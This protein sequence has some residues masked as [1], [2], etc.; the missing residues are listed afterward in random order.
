MAELLRTEQIQIKGNDTLSKMCHISKNLYN[1][2]NYVIRQEFFNNGKWIRYNELDKLMQ[3]SENYRTLPSA[4]SQQT[5]RVLDRNWSSFFKANK[6]YKN[7]PSKFLGKPKPPKYLNKDGEFILIFSNTK[8]KIKDG[9]LIIALKNKQGKQYNRNELK[10]KTRFSSNTNLREVRIIPKSNHYVCEIIYEKQSE[11]EIISR[12][13]YSKLDKN[14][15]KNIIGIDYG[16]SNIVTI[17]NNIGLPPI[18]IKDDG[19]GIKSIN[20]YYNKKKASLQSIYD[21]QGIKFGNKMNRLNSKRNAKIKDGMHKISKFIIDYCVDYDIE[22]ISIGH[23]DGWKQKVDLGKRTNQKF[24]TI[25]FNTLTSMIEYK[26]QEEGIRILTPKEDHT[27][28]CSFLDMESIEHHDS[29]LGT[30]FSRGLFRSQNN[31]IINSDV[32]GAYNIIRRS[33]PKAFIADCVGGCGL[34]PIR[35]NPLISRSNN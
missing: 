33:E 7:N 21:K 15:N 19:I 16:I 12:R 5:L 8:I 3:S 4:N 26:A 22:T 30:R 31:I 25:P 24:V 34:H 18:V 14:K 9:N 29:Y 23:N 20:Q 6:E 10:I 2:T 35:M 32:N 27:S 28:K 1:E 17:A 13:W 11:K